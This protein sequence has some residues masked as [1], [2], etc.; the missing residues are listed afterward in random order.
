MRVVEESLLGR[1]GHRRARTPSRGMEA[2][3]AIPPVL[4]AGDYVLGVAMQS[5][6]QRFFDQEVL[7]FRLWPPPDERRE[8]WSATGSY[9]R[10]SLAHGADGAAQGNRLVT[11]VLPSPSSCR[12]S[13]GR[14]YSRQRSSRPL[15]ARARGRDDRRRPEPARRRSRNRRPVRAFRRPH[16]QPVRSQQAARTNL[17]LQQ[18]RNEVVLVTDDDCTVA[19]S[20]STSPGGDSGASRRDHYRAGAS[21]WRATRCAVDDRRADTARLHR[22]DPLRGALRRQHGLQPLARSRC[23][24][25]RRAAPSRRGQRLLLPLASCG[26]SAPLRA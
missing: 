14:D 10:P 15:L 21:T 13:A 19:P 22:R 24:R 5:P 8:P 25:L 12:L 11:E 26:W 1:R 7:T 20:W 3:L 18:A 23:R 16:G 6:Y 17:G 2:S 4:A 9:R